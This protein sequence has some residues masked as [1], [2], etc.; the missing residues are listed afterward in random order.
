MRT[1][2]LAS[3]L[4][5][6]ACRAD[7][8]P[9]GQVVVTVWTDAPLPGDSDADSEGTKPVALFDRLRFD[10]VPPG[11]DL[12]CDDCSREFGIDHET[13][14]SGSASIGIAPPVDEDGWRVRVRLYRSGGTL[15]PDPR[16]G[17]TLEKVIALPAVR[18]EGKVP[19]HVVLFTETVAVP[20]GSITEP[21]EPDTGPF[22]QPGSWSGAHRRGC[23]EAPEPDEVCVPGGA[24]WMGDPRLDFSAAFDL[25]GS[26]ERLVVLDPFYLQ[27]TE[28]PVG[29]FRQSGLA[30]SLVPGGPSDNPHTPTA[31]FPQCTYTDEPGPFEDHPT[32]CLSWTKAQQ[33]CE[34]I[35][36]RLPTEAEL[37]YA[38]TRL[39][40]SRYVWGEELPECEDAVFDRQNDVDPCGAF[41]VGVALPGTGL[42]DRSTLPGGEVVDLAGNVQEWA[43]DRWNRQEE[44]CWGV[45]LF[46]NPS[47]D[48]PSPAD[49]GDVR[50]LR[51]GDWAGDEVTMR[52]AVR[53]RLVNET[54][55]VSARVGFRCA[56]AATPAE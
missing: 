56:R 47:C 54:Q 25:D 2:L 30:E 23:A 41:G 42:R 51:G 39:G 10:I 52:A 49:G 36:R 44:P 20:V 11:S 38:G 4:L 33:Y 35:G 34:S 28:V 19:L 55:A 37:E 40:R 26:L 53:T 13:V 21:H 16:P 14:A 15:S 22:P 1:P 45:G 7:L 9:E 50:V 24:Y 27:R 31:T 17:S 8:P 29:A 3:M 5:M 12:P 48:L 18:D 43:L 46:D 6:A 32:V